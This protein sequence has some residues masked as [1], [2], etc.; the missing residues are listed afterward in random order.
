[1][2]PL[3]NVPA[4]V[5]AG[6]L[7]AGKTTL[8]SRLLDW[9]PSGQTWAVLVNER[10]AGRVESCDG[11]AVTAV[12]GGCMCCTA[13]VSLRVALTRLLREARPSRLFVEL[14]GASHVGP[15]L[16][17]LTSPWLAPVLALGPV[18]MVIGS[19][20]GEIDRALV[21][22]ADVLCVR[23]DASAA[24]R[25]AAGKRVV[26]ADVATLA[27]LYGTTVNEPR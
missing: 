2:R 18:V 13:E 10:G 8:I 7:G 15:I 14:H 17:T 11:V 12:D 22:T 27:D 26:D 9:R 4:L 23:G 16:K 19:A 1:M 24:G 25:W 3:S 20:A 5:I 21:A 6:R